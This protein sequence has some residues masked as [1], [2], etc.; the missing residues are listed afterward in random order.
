MIVAMIV[1][2]GFA[3]VISRAGFATVPTVGALA[4]RAA[5]A[6][7][8]FVRSRCLEQAHARR[9]GTDGA[10]VDRGGVDRAR[11]RRQIRTAHRRQSGIHRP[12]AVQHRRRLHVGVS[13]LRIVQPQRRELRSRRMHAVVGRV[14]GALA[15]RHRCSPSGRWPPTCRSPP[16]PRCCSSLRGG[17][18]TSSKFGGSRGPI[19][20]TSSSSRSLSSSTL[21]I[22][23]DFAIFVG[24]L[25]SLLV[26]L[27]RT[28]HPSLTRVAPDARSPQR[29]FAPQESRGCAVPAARHPAHR[30]LA[31]LRCGRACP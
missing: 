23:L 7:G 29:R 4:V 10:R 6:V 21:T 11:H 18:S 27:N 19:A 20:A 22:Q 12:G 8:A 1:G 5:G 30:R 26:Y 13:V 9:F 16:W 25:A 15:G 31:V 14:F 2:G 3:Y 24:V 28:T 17:S